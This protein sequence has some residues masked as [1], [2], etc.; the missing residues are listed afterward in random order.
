ME[1]VSRLIRTFTPEHYELSIKLH[2]KARTFEGTV[3][4]RGAVAANKNEIRLHAKDLTIHS[5]TFD[6]KEA[7]FEPAQHDELIITHADITEGGHVVVVV[8]SGTITDDMN[9]IYPGY[10]EVE[11]QK[12]ELIATQFESHYARQA[13]PCVDEPEAKATFDV[14]ISTEQDV[15]VL[16]N[17]PVRSQEVEGDWLVTTFETTPRMSSYLVAWVVG[18]LQKKTATTKGGVEVNVW[19]TKAHD[20]SNLDF[21]LGIAARTIDF[22]DEYFGI[23]YPLPKSDHVALPD[24]S[25]GAMENWGLITYREIALLVDPKTTTL[26]T[27]HYAAAVIAHELSHQW[28]G[29]LVTMKWWNNLWLNESFANMMEY[30][31]VDAL[32][33]SWDIWLDFATNE[34]VSALRRD[35]LD[36]VQPIQID[37]NHPDEISTIFDPSIVY[38]KGGRLLRMLQAYVGTD[39]MKTGLK[40]YFERHKYTNTEAEDLWAALSEASGKDIASFMHSWMTQPGFPVVRAHA[41][42]ETITLTQKQ[43][44]NGPHTDIGRS[45]PIP[46]HGASSQIPETLQETETTFTYSDTQP[47]RLNTNGTAHFI[48]QYDDRLLANIVRNIDTLTSVDK[49]NF[50]HEQVLLAKAGLQSNATLIPLLYHFKEETNEAVWSIVSLA[51]NELKRFVEN[52]ESAEQKLKALTGEVISTQYDRLGWDCVDGEDEN[53]TKLRSTIIALSLY[54]ELPASLTEAKNRYLAGPIATLDSELRVAI[55]ANA[56][57]REIGDSVIEKLLAAYV[58]ETNSELR[59]DIAAA[60]TSTRDEKTIAKLA[61]LMQ[62][63]KFVRLQDFTHWFVWLLRNRFGRAYMWQ[64]AQ[65]NWGWMVKTFK[66]DSSYDMLPRYIAASLVTA[67]QEQEFKTFFAPLENEVALARNIKIGYT[68]LEGIVRL[69]ENDGPKVREVLIDL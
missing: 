6:G 34:V 33:P 51:I 26:S 57:R 45:W 61:G 14:T 53:D 56:V 31:A 28:F 43:F 38:A 64:W 4:I 9:G 39:A 69:L 65:D 37:V 7:S 44:F 59:D 60:L 47:F 68:E 52:D 63:A 48:T 30:V 13:F 17:M 21:A 35:S 5:I 40:L 32:E 22:F 2:R 3:T 15:T 55:M 41:T 27:K 58:K 49:V 11:G 18:D 66:G 36:G 42:N 46:L 20:P 8:F 62:D 67:Q 19:S 12:Q 50:L 16:G 10:F 23:P 29:N 25:S 1:S 24:F 54:A